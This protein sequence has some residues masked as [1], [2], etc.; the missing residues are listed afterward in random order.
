M[1]KIKMTGLWDV[2]P[3]SLEVTGRRFRGAY[4]RYHH[5]LP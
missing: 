1:V 5:S 4:C 3:C 2:A